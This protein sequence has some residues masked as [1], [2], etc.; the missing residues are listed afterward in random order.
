MEKTQTEESATKPVI[1]DGSEPRRLKAKGKG[2]AGLGG[3]A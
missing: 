2:M 3:A 1:L